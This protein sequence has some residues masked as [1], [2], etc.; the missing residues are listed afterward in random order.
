M[1]IISDNEMLKALGYGEDS[2]LKYNGAIEATIRSFK[3][4]ANHSN[5]KGDKR[6]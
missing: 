2:T 1:I 4:Y 6:K 3:E 5:I